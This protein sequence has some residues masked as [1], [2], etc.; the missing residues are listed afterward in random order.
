MVLK[1]LPFQKY[2]YSEKG[3]RKSCSTNNIITK[4]RIKTAKCAVKQHIY[5]FDINNKFLISKLLNKL[6]TGF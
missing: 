4:M 5:N 2:T 1:H 3:A 6:F